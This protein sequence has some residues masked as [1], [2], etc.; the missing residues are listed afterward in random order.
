ME[1]YGYGGLLLDIRKLVRNYISVAD[2]GGGYGGAPPP[3]GD[4]RAGPKAPGILQT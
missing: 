1:P 2:L 4:D 3:L